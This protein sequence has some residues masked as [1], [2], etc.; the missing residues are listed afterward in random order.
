MFPKF[1]KTILTIALV[2]FV[3]VTLFAAAPRPARAQ[4]PT[5]DI[6]QKAW[7]IIKD[8]AARVT[9]SLTQAGIMALFNATQYFVQKLAY[10]AAVYVASGGSGQK[11]LFDGKSFGDYVRDTALDSAMT[12]ITNFSDSALG[13]YGF[14][15]CAPSISFIGKIKIG[16]LGQIQMLEKPRCDFQQ[17]QASWDQFGSSIGNGKILKNFGVMFE[18][19]N[20]ELGFALEFNSKLI[21]DTQNKLNQAVAERTATGGWK[22][23]KNFVS[24]KVTTPADIMK[25]MVKST[26]IEEPAANFRGNMQMFAFAMKDGV[27]AILPTALS[28]FTNTLLNQSMKRV[29]EGLFKDTPSEGG[30]PGEN[31]ANPVGSAIG[32]RAAELVY[33]DLIKPRIT[34]STNYD[35]LSEFTIC[36]D[37]AEEK[38]INNCVI[39]EGFAAAVRLADQGRPISIAE[40]LKQGYLDGNKLLI[41]SRD[42]RNEQNNC[43]QQGYCFSNLVK[44]RKARIIPAGFELA[45][46]LGA[47]LSGQTV[48]A[49]SSGITIPTLKTAVDGFNDCGKDATTGADIR[50]ASHPWCRLIDPNWV[51]RLPKTQCLAKVYGPTLAS[52]AGNF[53][54]ETCADPATCISQDADG[55]CTD[56]FGYCTKEKNIWRI[57]ADKCPEQFNT[58][59]TY[60]ARDNK[61][62]NYLRNTVDFNSCSAV[63]AGC[64]PYSINQTNNAWSMAAGDAVYFNKDIEKCD[65]KNAGCT[66]IYS[67]K[68][69][70][71]YNLLPNPSFEIISGGDAAGWRRVGPTLPL[72]EDPT[73]SFDGK[74]AAQ[75]AS[76]MDVLET[77]NLIKLELNTPYALSAYA[78]N[79]F[80]NTTAQ[81][82]LGM[83]LFTDAAGAA[84]YDAN[85]LIST[86]NKTTADGAY[87]YQEAAVG[88]DAFTRVSCAFLTPAVTLY[89][90]IFVSNSE[91]DRTVWYDAI[92]LEEGA[93]PTTFLSSGYGAVNSVFTKI[94]PDYLDCSIGST[95]PQ[96]AAYAPTCKAEEVGCERYTPKGGNPPI[97]GT[98][99]VDDICPKDCAGYETYK[100]EKV[101]YEAEKFPLYFIPQTAKTCNAEDV[102]CDEFTNLSTEAKEY[103]NYIRQ[104]VKLTPKEWDS[105]YT[106][107]GSDATGYQLRAHRLK[108]GAA[109][110]GETGPAPAITDGNYAACTKAVFT[111][112]IS[113]PNYNPDCREFYNA[114]GQIS[115]RL[116]SKTI[117]A[118]DECADFR[119]TESN[120]SDCANSGGEWNG[121]A[122]YCLYR[123]YKTESRVC[124]STSNS[125]RAYSG[126][127]ASNL[128]IVFQDDFEG[129]NGG[130]SG[131]TVSAES[132]SAGG[133][134]LKLAPSVLKAEALVKSLANLAYPNST[135]TLSF[136]AKGAGGEILDVSM[137]AASHGSALGP[138]FRITLKG[139]WQYFELGPI[140]T[141]A[142]AAARNLAIGMSKGAGF[143][144]DNIILNEAGQKL[145]LIKNSWK[146][147]TECDQTRQGV[148]L[149]QAQLG[150][151]EYAT[152]TNQSAYLKSFSSLCRDEA[153]GCSALKNSYN[154]AKDFN[155]FYNLIC[156]LPNTLGGECKYNG[157]TVCS[158]GKGVSVCRFNINDGSLT[159]ADYKKLP[160]YKQ[161][162]YTVYEAF[163]AA[164]RAQSASGG[165]VFRDE[166]TV[167]TPA[168]KTIYIVDDKKYYCQEKDAS[169]S[170][171]GQPELYKTAG[172]ATAYYKNNPDDYSKVLCTAEAEGCES[173]TSG[174]GID[175][176]KVPARECEYREASAGILGG[177]YK[178]GT[179]D[180]CY[181]TKDISGANIPAVLQNGASGIWR[182][183]DAGYDGAAGLCTEAQNECTEFIDPQDTSSLNLKGQPY[184]LLYNDKL[185]ALEADPACSGKGSLSAGCV[186]FNKTSELALKWNAGATYLKADRIKQLAA[187][188]T[189]GY[190]EYGTPTTGITGKTIF[191]YNVDS[192]KACLEDKDCLSIKGTSVKSGNVLAST[193]SL[194]TGTCREW[195]DAN[196]VLKVT[197]DRECAEW[198]SCKTSY[199][200]TDPLTQKTKLVCAEVGLCNKAALSGGNTC[201]NFIA[202]P[203]SG[204]IL[205]A[206]NYS[207]RQIGWTGR[208]YSGYSIGGQYPVTDA[209]FDKINDTGAIG[210]FGGFQGVAFGKATYYDLKGKALEFKNQSEPLS[211]RGYP[212]QDSPFPFSVAKYDLQG[213]KD[214]NTCED[215]KNCECNYNKLTYGSGATKK[216]T[217]YGN[218]NV[219]RGICQGG[220]YDGRP[221]QPGASFDQDPKNSCG[222]PNQGGTCLLL[223][224]QDDVIGWQGYCLERDLSTPLNGNKNQR[225]CLTWLPQD[226]APGARDIYNQFRLAGY[227]PPI[228]G[229][230]Y[231]C[232][233]A[234]GEYVSDAV[235]VNPKNHYLGFLSTFGKQTLNQSLTTDNEC[236]KNRICGTG[237]SACISS[238]FGYMQINRPSACNSANAEISPWPSVGA[239]ETWQNN[240]SIS[241]VQGE[242]PAGQTRRFF[243][244]N[245]SAAG[246][247]VNLIKVDNGTIS[248]LEGDSVRTDKIEAIEIKFVGTNTYGDDVPK[249]TS[250]YI[251]NGKKIKDYIAG[252]GYCDGVKKTDNCAGESVGTNQIKQTARA[253]SGIELS[254]DGGEYWYWRYDDGQTPGKDFKDTDFFGSNEAFK[255]D[256]GGGGNQT[257]IQLRFHFGIN[258]ILDEIAVAHCDT[259]GKKDTDWKIQ[260]RVHSR[261][262]CTEIVDVASSK[263]AALTDNIWKD[264]LNNIN[265][266]VL[267]GG[268]YH[269][270][271]EVQPFG[272]AAADVSPKNKT[273]WYSYY[274]MGRPSF[275]GV[276]WSC[277]KNCG[278]PGVL[279]DSKYGSDGDQ[280]TI[281]FD[282]SQ[283]QPKSQI[284]NQGLNNFSSATNFL[285]NLFAKVFHAYQYNQT[286]GQ[287][288]EPKACPDY[289]ASQPGGCYDYRANASAYPNLKNPQIYSYKVSSDGK[290]SLDKSNALVINGASGA[291]AKISGNQ[292]LATIRFYAWAD[293]NKMPLTSIKAD[294]DGDGTYDFATTDGLYKNH[295]PLCAK[296]DNQANVCSANNNIVCSTAVDCPGADK[297]EGPLVLFGNSSDACEEGYFEIQ[298]IYTCDKPKGQT[299]EFTPKISVA[300]NWG[301]VSVPA[302]GGK[303]TLTP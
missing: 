135:Y 200:A 26:T 184:Y 14:N 241:K 146:T 264:N 165:S 170:A 255:N 45:A 244:Q 221:C 230:K 104:C 284:S 233:Q 77:S 121:A 106:W 262:L 116:L 195:A 254:P 143:Y 239:G 54:A 87:H 191:N 226:V 123:G 117:I 33:S 149:P 48:A 139:D 40:A 174:R 169:C 153:V 53:R 67:K 107:E 298:H 163:A 246:Q 293:H 75:I 1:K 268:P 23:V 222:D 162:S 176:F 83:R 258:K 156:S 249:G 250:F 177:W 181:G 46:E 212:E 32:R 263:N 31:P 274:T 68:D 130:W 152:R 70:L 224:R 273:A 61:Q 82:V 125:C 285:R 113:D 240:P 96:C 22:D 204:V 71:A 209:F 37:K 124:A 160:L 242:D 190:C 183:A 292:Y 279:K 214:A 259:S 207:K 73:K 148:L 79:N 203:D 20:S 44:L 180:V 182:N 270:D 161:S 18:P 280:T 216:Y 206:D 188:Q 277:G 215:G 296:S 88:A 127:A 198:L 55:K 3:S 112:K 208:E 4:L 193:A 50:D 225:A 69:G 210:M 220:P 99:T 303:I 100:Q 290:Y 151:K 186:L 136:W 42:A 247:T 34:V 57:P 93:A 282:V 94:A 201:A 232:L 105:F 248:A 172:A 147:P 261:E 128:R 52:T 122:Q 21:A 90:R 197:R 28:T 76:R 6:T 29:M 286:T 299:C 158:T 168:D 137:D 196:T 234:E 65:A 103:F 35:P 187:P 150:C 114:A 194:Y 102:G 97:S 202:N 95:D 30:A 81:A 275:A 175:Y 300:D 118:T 78:K 126:A 43:Y 108:V 51:L 266:T 257:A 109:Q 39:D 115:Y 110:A 80:P 302:A 56:G 24:G 236:V 178:K 58:C 129:G 98:P 166:S 8:V 294:W 15:V 62:A 91:A 60:K 16:A 173:W 74:V 287:Y 167:M 5:T 2:C 72:T 297:C 10:D 265:K 132:L 295:K 12:F 154:S 185:K 19:G 111:A 267:L 260:L 134:S 199:S 227:T 120:Q 155:E 211:C 283:P 141:S 231:Y 291:D 243:K 142:S 179:N 205:T 25:E 288:D 253:R 38:Q 157:K 289:P 235:A 237:E 281:D 131:G 86:C 64:R 229:G 252:G 133:H 41:S 301:A 218:R 13:K 223:K 271:Y 101:S 251:E 228:G 238:P 272:S 84:P 63:N 92:Q 59:L 278:T 144:I 219:D 9:T 145:Y 192:S 171:L 85:T 27:Y 140:A 217:E 17:F 164:L 245:N 276:P 89:A 49:K 189:K 47:S 138:N 213:Y 269:Y 119:K 256:C 159:E 11:P 66:E 36:P 7:N